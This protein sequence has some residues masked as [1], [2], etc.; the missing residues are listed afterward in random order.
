MASG[1]EQLGSLDVSESHK[2][3]DTGGR[4]LPRASA[5]PDITIRLH[6]QGEDGETHRVINVSERGAFVAGSGF[7][8]GEVVDFELRGPDFHYVG[9][10]EVMHCCERGFG[11]H[12]LFWEGPIERALRTFVSSRMTPP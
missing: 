11:L 8:V 6:R 10:A 1:Q 7:D 5:V 9:R 4:Q 2:A 3:I 12:V